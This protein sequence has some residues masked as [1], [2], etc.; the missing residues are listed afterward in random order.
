MG[1]HPFDGKMCLSG[2][3]WPENG[4]NAGATGAGIAIGR[5]GEGNGHRRSEWVME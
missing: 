4:R 3:G 2:I 5:G 1:E